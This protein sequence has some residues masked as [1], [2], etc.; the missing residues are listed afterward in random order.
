MSEAQSNSQLQLNTSTSIDSSG[1]CNPEGYSS[2]RG[3]SMEE[4]QGAVKDVE[5]VSIYEPVPD[6]SASEV[7]ET[8]EIAHVKFLNEKE[9]DRT[10][11]KET[12]ETTEERIT[13]PP[14]L[15]LDSKENQKSQQQEQVEY[16]LKKS[17]SNRNSLE[18]EGSVLMKRFSAS[19]EISNEPQVQLKEQ[20]KP[21]V[22]RKLSRQ[23]S[24]GKV[25]RQNTL[26]M[27]FGGAA[28]TSK[29]VSSQPSLPPQEEEE[30]S[31]PEKVERG[32]RDSL[33][34]PSETMC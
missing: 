6:D 12:F 2:S 17:Y 18:S 27:E 24:Q 25:G 14:L 3:N 11:S 10:G 26:A 7:F 21:T 5:R 32:S 29:K 31:P 19:S 23:E 22:A 15:D 28:H 1:A 30:I 4:P 20:T 16:P 8:D 33:M 13:Q 34:M 9:I